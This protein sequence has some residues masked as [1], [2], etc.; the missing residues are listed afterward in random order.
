MGLK[1][2]SLSRAWGLGGLDWT[3]TSLVRTQDGNGERAKWAA[4]ALPR[5][6]L[7]TSLS[8]NIRDVLYDDDK[9]R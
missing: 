3:V 2:Q 5:A 4:L 1:V 6:I 8:W 7:S 9:G